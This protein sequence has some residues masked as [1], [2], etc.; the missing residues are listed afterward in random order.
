MDDSQRALVTIEEFSR[1][2]G[3]KYGMTDDK[4]G[5]PRHVLK[6]LKDERLIFQRKAGNGHVYWY[7]TDKGRLTAG[8]AH[9][10][11]L[12]ESKLITT[13]AKCSELGTVPTQKSMDR[14]RKLMLELG[15]I[16]LTPEELHLLEHSTQGS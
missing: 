16:G 2:S 5:V 3:Y 4:I 1:K 14:A 10:Q 9:R 7:L 8:L 12:P 11:Q 13:C 15:K 6:Y